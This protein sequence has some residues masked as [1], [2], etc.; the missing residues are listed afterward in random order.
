MNL[1]KL[2][3]KRTN[4]LFGFL[5]LLPLVQ[6]LASLP[7]VFGILFV[8]ADNF[9][10]S[11]AAPQFLY[12]LFSLAV[13]ILCPLCFHVNPMTLLHSRKMTWGEIAVSIPILLGTSTV[14]EYLVAWLEYLLGVEVPSLDAYMTMPETWHEWIV[15][16]VLITVFPAICEEVI[17]RGV[18]LGSLAKLN[19]TVAVWLSAFAFGLMH[20]TVQQIPFAFFAGLIFGFLYVRFGS[21]RICIVLHFLNNLIATAFMYLDTV[22]DSDTL[23]RI[24]WIYLAAVVF[25]AIAGWIVYG[26]KFRRPRSD[27]PMSKGEAVKSSLKSAWLWVYLIL[28]VLMTWANTWIM[29]ISENIPSV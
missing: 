29:Q 1:T 4:F 13:L 2:F 21:L 12:P 11:F 8:N 19:P 24:E 16:T 3:T 6:V 17:Y 7:S 14:F 22:M 9:Y 15:F 20:A 18:L 23:A 27:T 25:G 26:L 28:L 5:C 10:I